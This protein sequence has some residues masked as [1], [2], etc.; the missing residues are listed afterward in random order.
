M[1]H[2]LGGEEARE[3]LLAARLCTALIVGIAAT[4]GFITPFASV[5]AVFSAVSLLETATGTAQQLTG[6]ESGLWFSLRDRTWQIGVIAQTQAGYPQTGHRTP[7][8]LP[9]PT[10]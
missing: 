9:F 8:L 1:S 2:C 10:N 5:G 7:G 6:F 4:A 3:S